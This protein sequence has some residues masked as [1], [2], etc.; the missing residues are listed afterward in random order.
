MKRVHVTIAGRVQG[1]CYRLETQS[2]ARRL[3]VVGWVRNL[4][5]GRVEGLFEGEDDQV[6][7][8]V[9]WCRRGPPL[10]HVTDVQERDAEAAGDLV[11]FRIR[12]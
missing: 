4:P 7:A 2:E 3:G 8:L 10:A 12:Y 11:E 9:E 5:D 6:D 1:V